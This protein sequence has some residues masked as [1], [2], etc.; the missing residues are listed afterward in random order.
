MNILYLLFLSGLLLA[1]WMA[2]TKL[3][4]S[5]TMKSYVHLFCALSDAQTDIRIMAYIAFISILFLMTVT[6]LITDGNL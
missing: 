1:E 3:P 2:C 4:L 6:S 5:G